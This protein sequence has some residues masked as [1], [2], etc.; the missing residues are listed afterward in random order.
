M[1][2]KSLGIDMKIVVEGYDA[3]GKSTL[4]KALAEK[5]GL[6]LV[7]AGPKPPSNLDAIA[8]SDIQAR[9]DNVVHSRITPISRQAYQFDNS[10][11]HVAHLRAA[12]K[13][14]QDKDTIFIFCVGVADEHEVKDYDTEEHL[15]FLKNNEERIRE[16]YWRLFTYIPHIKYNFKTDKLEDILCHIDQTVK[17]S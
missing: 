15:I 13:M 10:P 12:F 1:Q 14:F 17:P 6:S 7:E 3:S 5:Y 9:M 2:H 4:A 16:N 11:I 8:D